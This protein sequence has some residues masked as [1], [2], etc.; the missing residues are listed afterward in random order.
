MKENKYQ[1]RE[2]LSIIHQDYRRDFNKQCPGGYVE[3]DETWCIC[4][5]HDTDTVLIN[6]ARDL[7]DYFATSMH[8]SLQ[9]VDVNNVDGYSKRILYGTDSMLSA[10]SYRFTVSDKE[11]LL[12]GNNSR[13]AAQ[14]GYFVEDLMNL[15]EGPYLEKQNI[16]RSSLF[17]P[18]MVHSGFGLDMYPTEHLINIAHAGISSIL[19]FVKDINT[20]PHGYLDFNDL[21]I[22]AAEHGLDVYAYSY[23]Q[24]KLHP[25]D[26]DAEEFYDRLYGGLFDSC[27][28]FKGIIFVG[29]SCEFPSKD[30]HSL[31]VR[32]LD[33]QDENGNKILKGKPHPGWWPCY[34]YVELMNV[35]KKAIYKRR[36]DADIVL[37]SYNWKS[38][39]Y[40]DRKALI[41]R[42]PKDITLQ[43]TF[44]MGEAYERDGV[45]I[46]T[47]D[48]NLAFAGPSNYFLTEGKS[49]KENSLKF[50]SMTNTGGL[51]WDFGVIPYIPAPYQW[52]K[53]YKG[54]IN[55]H[56]HLG[57]C[58][59]MDCH[60]Y[61]FTP[62]FISDLAKWAFNTPAVDLNKIVHKLAGRDFSP[63]CADVVCD[64]YRHLSEGM[65]HFIVSNADQY[66]PCRMGPAYPFLFMNEDFEI[67][68]DPRAH[69]HITCTVY[70]KNQRKY[71]FRKS[72]GLL[73]DE[74]AIKKFY[75]QLDN[76][77]IAQEHFDKACQLLSTVIT[78]IPERKRENAN[79]ILGLCLFIRNTAR[80][81]IGIRNF[82][83]IKETFLETH[84]EERNRAVDQ[85]IKISRAEYDN[86][87]D[88]LP[89]VEFDS[90]LGYEPSMEYRCD[91]EHI[92]WKLDLLR[93][94]IEKELPSY[95][96]K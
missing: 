51:T 31:G 24:N 13:M 57:L 56:Y 9:L 7:V 12:V 88:T 19:V 84:G 11:I 62:S 27:P 40:E 50:Y 45:T 70:G 25:D 41:D 29:E 16:V 28:H 18:R 68:R 4:V 96:E 6:A 59:I 32:R 39:P 72:T 2:R 52:V 78:D 66:G 10:H 5:P 48:Y 61:G 77:K 65:H 64:A 47:P 26:E 82:F 60:H 23:L 69:F 20:T 42:L 14:A 8:I 55:A 43:A 73:K 15:E 90:R 75:C 44:E 35:I 36:P 95:Y 86:A 83:L 54:M 79:R 22:R 94:V 38:A 67:P 37:W 93:D 76:I 92:H 34:D 85:L 58:G 3:V 46:K 49:A 81:T 17:N 91:P 87:V 89:L 71:P 33:N 30:P 74:L 1:F 63:E 21:C 80:T 53:R